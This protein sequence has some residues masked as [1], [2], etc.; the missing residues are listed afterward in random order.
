MVQRKFGSTSL[1]LL[2]WSNVSIEA[3]TEGMHNGF[4]GLGDIGNTELH[5]FKP[6]PDREEY[7]IWDV[8]Y[9]LGAHTFIQTKDAPAD[10]V[11]LQTAKRLTYLKGKLLEEM[12]TAKKVFVYKIDYKIPTPVDDAVMR[13]IY[14]GARQQG[15]VTLM[16]V[17][18]EDAA[19]PAGSVR[20]IED[21]LYAGYVRYFMSETPG[22]EAETIDYATW[23]AICTDVL[24]RYDAAA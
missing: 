11:L 19:N 8:K 16:C 18:K 21:N 23:Q 24:A 22:G 7:R 15:A 20:K 17:L 3:L 4:Q 5:T 13:A 6:V 12:G 1:S 14:A 10:K 2:R 9:G